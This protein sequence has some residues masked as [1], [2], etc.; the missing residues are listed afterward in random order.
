MGHLNFS[1]VCCSPGIFAREALP[2][3][4]TPIRRFAVRP[5]LHHPSAKTRRGHRA[6]ETRRLSTFSRSRMTAK[7]AEGR[8]A[9]AAVGKRV[10]KGQGERFH[11]T[12]LPITQSTI[13][14]K[15]LFSTG[16]Q[17]AKIFVVAFAVSFCCCFHVS[18]FVAVVV[19][20]NTFIFVY[21]FFFF[22]LF[23]FSTLFLFS[24]LLSFLL[25]FKMRS[26]ISISGYVRRSVRPSHT[27]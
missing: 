4:P 14:Q 1:F 22:S 27:S 5:I 17:K 25:Y 20:F 16:S 3:V 13:H 2:R 6:R 24:L 7:E 11:L 12:F 21:F 15:A 9:V 23:F 8:E 10:D 18:F 19:V 26:R